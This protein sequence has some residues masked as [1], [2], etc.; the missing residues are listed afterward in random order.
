MKFTC[1]DQTVKTNCYVPPVLSNGSLTT[2]IDFRG[3][4]RQ[5]AY[6][7][8]VP[9]IYRAGRRYDTLRGELFPLGCFFSERDPGKLRS[10]SQTLDCEEALVRAQCRYSG[11][12]TITT[13]AFVHWKYNVLAVRKEFSGLDSYELKYVLGWSIPPDLHAHG[14]SAQSVRGIMTPEPPYGM[15]FSAVSAGGELIIDYR[16]TDRRGLRGRTRLISPTPG[17]SWRQQDNEFTLVCPSGCSGCD[18]LIVTTDDLDPA[19]ETAALD[20][21]TDFSFDRL[22]DSHRRITRKFWSC[23]RLEIPDKSL[24]GLYQTS[25]YYLRC[26]STRWGIPAGV[27]PS[28]WNGVYFGF[29][30]FSQALCGAGHFH[31]ALKVAR[32]RRNTLD[33]AIRRGS[34]GSHAAAGAYFAHES[35]EDGRERSSPGFWIDHVFQVGCVAAE[36]WNNYQYRPDRRYLDETAYPVLLNCAEFFRRRMVV[37][38]G[39]GRVI[40]GRCTD[41]E[42]LGPLRS[43]AFLTTC[44]AIASLEYAAAAADELGRDPELRELWSQTAARLRLHLPGDGEKYL[45]A[46]DCTEPSFGLNGAFYPCD[47]LSPRD[48][49]LRA[50]IDDLCRRSHQCGNMYRVGIGMCTWYAAWLALSL[51][52]MRD[53]RSHDFLR[54]AAANA[55]CFSEVFEINEPGRHSSIPWCTAPAGT[56][57]R[58]VQDM[59]L[60]IDREELSIAPGVPA[61]WTEWSFTLFAHD[62][63]RISATRRREHI[64]IQIR[65]GK[66]HSGIPRLVKGAGSQAR[67]VKLHPGET[68]RFTFS[69]TDSAGLPGQ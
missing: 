36:V 55:G 31:E 27:F 63:L 68:V 10:W 34:S 22:L 37:E 16:L 23:S 14:K 11:R 9:G 33:M 47:V 38:L 26:C 3:E 6:C 41:L 64:R 44:F 19:A 69:A 58:A 39:D 29:N 21:L 48:P 17:V 54:L 59:M 57:C 61:A 15:N 13:T 66:L 28:H 42:R 62:D 43:N 12:K 2:Q 25:M 65:A 4:Q 46:P 7:R 50:A 49:R 67:M 40:I 52:R 5:Y 1:T 56:Y 53:E 35:D 60:G 30:N 18:L 51:R 32:F 45:P 8:M 24:E 20:R